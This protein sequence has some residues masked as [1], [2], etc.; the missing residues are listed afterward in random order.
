MRKFKTI[1]TAAIAAMSITGVAVY[2]QSNGPNPPD[3]GGV[4][5]AFP[6]GSV[7]GAAQLYAAINPNGSTLRGAGNTSST[8]L[9]PGVY[10]VR[11]R[12]NISECAW[13]G[14]IGF[15]GFSGSTGPSHISVTGRAGTTNGVFV[16]TW[17]AVGTPTDLPFLLTVICG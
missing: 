17:N 16:Q 14:T 11:F 2:A 1:F 10:D 7:F 3:G 5:P 4:A 13:S 6:G 9:A 15:G 8:R 12:R